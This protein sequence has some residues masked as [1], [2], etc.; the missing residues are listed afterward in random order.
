MMDDT[1]NK[2]S[3]GFLKKSLMFLSASAC[4]SL[5]Y[6]SINQSASK[7]CLI[8]SLLVCLSSSREAASTSM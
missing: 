2:T 1:L 8:T 5:Q 4:P 3:L 6:S 7:H